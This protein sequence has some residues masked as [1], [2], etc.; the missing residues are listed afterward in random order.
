[1]DKK[2]N[3]NVQEVKHECVK[4]HP[5]CT[6]FPNSETCEW[7]YDEKEPYIKRRKNKDGF[8]CYYDGHTIKSWD[9][10]CPRENT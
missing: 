3:K 10:I 7:E 5:N 8:I 1:M 9:D 6:Y 2:S 4:C